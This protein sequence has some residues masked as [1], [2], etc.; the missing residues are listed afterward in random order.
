MSRGKKWIQKES[1]G[2]RGKHGLGATRLSLPV[3]SLHSRLLPC[4]LCVGNVLTRSLRAPSL[5]P[6][7]LIPPSFLSL[8][9]LVSFSLPCRWIDSYHHH[10]HPG[11]EDIV[12]HRE[13]FAGGR[14]TSRVKRQ[15]GV[16]ERQPEERS[17]SLSL[18]F[19]VCCCHCCC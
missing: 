2:R 5:L 12:S 19:I 11:K 9:L 13:Q 7:S 10:P 18:C 8:L 14:K 1:A 4:A 16:G 3:P 6:S 15:S 17:E